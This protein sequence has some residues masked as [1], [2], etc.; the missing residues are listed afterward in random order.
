MSD[1]EAHTN[2][3]EPFPAIALPITMCPSTPLLKPVGFGYI[4]YSGDI[5]N[6]GHR[7]PRGYLYQHS[8]D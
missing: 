6:I 3:V 7:L 8:V 2:V 4:G 1:T 5:D